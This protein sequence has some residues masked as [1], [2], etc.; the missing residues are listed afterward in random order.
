MDELEDIMTFIK[1]HF[2]FIIMLFVIVGFTFLSQINF[3]KMNVA[4]VAVVLLIALTF[5]HSDNENM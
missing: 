2:L 4:L 5:V 3:W 1:F